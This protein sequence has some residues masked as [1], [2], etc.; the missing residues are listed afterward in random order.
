MEVD[1]PDKVT[2]DAAAAETVKPVVLV[3]VI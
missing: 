3:R 1:E 2:S